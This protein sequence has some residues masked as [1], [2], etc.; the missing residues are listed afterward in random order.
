[1]PHCQI[2]HFHYLIPQKL[3]PYLDP[4]PHSRSCLWQWW[5]LLQ[6]HL[7]ENLSPMSSFPGHLQDHRLAGST[8][9]LD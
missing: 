4:V 6:A 5:S 2:L 7:W 1:M 3:T 9:S 8:S